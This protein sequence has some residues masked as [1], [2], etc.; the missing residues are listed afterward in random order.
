MAVTLERLTRR[1]DYLR[2]GQG[3]FKAVTPAFVLQA[4]PSPTG[5]G[6]VRVGFTASRKVGKAVDRNRA[7]RRLKELARMYLNKW[8][9]DGFDYVLIA[10]GA[11]VERP[12][13]ALVKDLRWAVAKIDRKR[14]EA[15]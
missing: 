3:G 4:A 5:A 9:A 7:R 13:S 15:A 2:L 10:R 12:F 11:A 8:G 6:S 1:A 14:E